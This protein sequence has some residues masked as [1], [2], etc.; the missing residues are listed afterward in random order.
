MKYRVRFWA[1]WQVFE[2]HPHWA[3]HTVNVK[4][5][6]SLYTL[7]EEWSKTGLHSRLDSGT[8][9]FLPGHAI[10]YIEAKE[11]DED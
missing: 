6:A 10:D 11:I 1:R 8:L 7:M 9:T 2:D 3:E 4:T 5:V